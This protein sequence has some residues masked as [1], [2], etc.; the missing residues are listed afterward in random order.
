M[1]IIN[2]FESFWSDFKGKSSEYFTNVSR[3]F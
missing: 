3:Y 1:K 2:I